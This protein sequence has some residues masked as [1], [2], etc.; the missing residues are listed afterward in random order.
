M[1][2]DTD[3]HSHVA[4]SSAAQMVQA[5]KAKGLH[6]LGLSEHVFQMSEARASLEH[7]HLEGPLLTFAAYFESVHRAAQDFQFD[8][9]V[10]LEVDYVPA[11]NEEI[12]AS[13]KRYNWDFLIGSVHE[14][15]GVVYEYVHRWS[16]VEGDAAWLRY[17]ELLRAAASSGHFSVVSHPV[18]MRVRNPYLPTSFDEELEK[19]AA[20]ATRWNVAL[21]VN[22]F[23]VLN[24]PG[25][26][27]RLVKAC[28]LQKTP[29]SVGSDAHDPRSVAQGQQQTE[30]ILRE[31]GITKVR[32]WKRCEIEEYTL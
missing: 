27:R 14:I 28:V 21:E 8:A 23:D 19:L 1:P 5:A 30:A 32:I 10:G 20:E 13:I 24:Y 31:A 7:I 15:D 26:V 12:I 4:R 29:I 9:R 22:G 3:F 2:I 16:S 18:R 11:R 6:V 17:F 25:V